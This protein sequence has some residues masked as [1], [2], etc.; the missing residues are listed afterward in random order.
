MAPATLL[1]AAERTVLERKLVVFVVLGMVLAPDSVTIA[2]S[3]PLF[4]AGAGD[5]EGSG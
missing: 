5:G 4:V 1:L 2:L 3:P